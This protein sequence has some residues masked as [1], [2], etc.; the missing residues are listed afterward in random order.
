M[1]RAPEAPTT[2]TGR[3]PLSVRAGLFAFWLAMLWGG[4]PV[5]IKAGL[6]HV[7]P[8]RL[9]ALRMLLGGIVVLLHA[10]AAGVSLRPTRSER[11]PLAGLA[12][13]FTVQTALMYFGGD[14]TSAGHAAVLVATFPLWAA[15]FAHFLV[16]GD[17]L[18]AA[19][20][21]G[22]LI[23]YAGVVVVF[24]GDLL[25]SR[26]AESDARLSGDV[27]MLCSALLLG[28][29]QIY[30]SQT[31]QAIP[32]ARLLMAQA[33]PAVLAFGLLSALFESGPWTFS[34]EFL[35]ALLYQGGVIAGFG[36]IGNAWLLQR[37]LPSRVAATQLA[38]PIFGVL[39]SWAI[40]G[41]SIGWE[42]AAGVALLVLGSA[43]VQ[44]AAAPASERLSAR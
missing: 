27:M 28:A 15:I 22:S 17:R 35:G 41:E 26:D 38:T 37:Y 36:F 25:G 18:T 39:L 43:A 33:L 44:R 12:V 23:A 19:R 11:R 10:R 1:E 2:D 32:P 5:A 24:S 13:I 4:N 21:F 7:Q 34:F 14:H 42:L 30:L 31:S 29:R 16:P 3:R 20:S 6:E 40:L 8:L 9:G